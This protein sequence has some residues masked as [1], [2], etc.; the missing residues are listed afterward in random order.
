MNALEERLGSALNARA[1][2]VQPEDLRPALL[3]G[4]TPGWRRPAVYALA[5]AAAVGVIA[6][7]FAFQGLTGDSDR[8]SPPPG[9]QSVVPVVEEVVGDVDGDGYEDTV[10]LRDGEL[11][12]VL[13]SSSSGKPLTLGYP[14]GRLLGLADLD[15]TGQ[16]IVLSVPAK[17]RSQAGDRDVLVLTWRGDGV[18]EVVQPG[19]PLS[20]SEFRTVWIA[21]GWLY[22]GQYDESTPGPG[23]RVQSFRQVV[24]DGSLGRQDAGTWCWDR[25]REPQPRVC[26]SPGEFAPDV[27]SKAG[28]PTLYP[29]LDVRY[30]AADSSVW[31]ATDVDQ[32]LLSVAFSGTVSKAQSTVGDGVLDLVV[33]RSGVQDRIGLPGGSVPEV[34]KTLVTLGDGDVGILV[35]RPSDDGSQISVYGFAGGRLRLV[36]ATTTAAPLGEGVWGADQRGY[37]SWVTSEGRL[38]TR[39]ET[40]SDAGRYE[41]WEWRLAGE[42]GVGTSLVADSLGEV[43]ID[44]QAD[45]VRY[46]AC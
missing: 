21:D 19:L 43:C 10:S 5:A 44:E 39:L 23:V 16:G 20:L 37:H 11:A 27:G 28:L 18:R 30:L 14:G 17:Q 29:E 35:Q 34:R 31:T 9:E 7:P 46:G 25:A 2:L 4:H 12:V 42:P 13:A 33:S 8:P 22:S 38:F 6:V 41:V 32:G 24:T 40:L 36:E 3:P 1:D 15:L 45:P 26:S